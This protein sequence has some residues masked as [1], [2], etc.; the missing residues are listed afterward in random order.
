MPSHVTG[1]RKKAEQGTPSEAGTSVSEGAH[2]IMLLKETKRRRLGP[3]ETQGDANSS[4]SSGVQA[5]SAVE[6]LESQLSLAFGQTASRFAVIPP[7]TQPRLTRPA[8]V[9]TP[10]FGDLSMPPESF[11]SQ[12]PRGQVSDT[13]LAVLQASGS[14][15]SLHS[16]GAPPRDADLPTILEPK[17]SEPSS[18]QYALDP[19]NYF[20]LPYSSC[21]SNLSFI[22][23]VPPG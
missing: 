14:S 19:A 9:N 3:K 2:P 8:S 12:A 21:T 20:R 11:A 15:P 23:F 18:L 22:K 13:P 5:T 1:K 6:K 7:L 10:H 4:A 16:S 17:R